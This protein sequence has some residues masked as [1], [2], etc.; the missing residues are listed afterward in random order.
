VSEDRAHY[1]DEDRANNP[2]EKHATMPPAIR[3][4]VPVAVVPPQPSRRER[5][6]PS[7]RERAEPLRPA[8]TG[9]GY[10]SAPSA[11]TR[12]AAGTVIRTTARGLGELLITL[13]AIVLLFAAYEFW[14]V[15]AIV[16]A[17]QDDL[18]RQLEQQWQRDTPTVGPTG[19]AGTSAP[20]PAPPAE[21]S[22]IGKLY[23]PRLNKWWVVVQGVTPKDIRYHPGHYPTTAMPGQEG[24]FSVAGH[25]NRATFW[26][27]D[28]MR[29]DDPIVVRTR[30]TW[31][32]YR[33]STTR[34][35]APTQ[36]EV[37]S[38]NPPGQHATRLLT[39]TTCNPK[40]DNY[41]RLIVHAEY[42]REQPTSAGDPVEL[43]G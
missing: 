23:L 16:D 5:A 39:L 33:V 35:V 19:S 34:V 8:G 11:P 1:P 29:N 43:K 4:R 18:A 2:D 12:T 15:S 25:R 22:G 42:V 40:L 36:V 14:G 27:L 17:H 38:P 41:Q 7:R 32:V 9:D 10:R 30:D 20:A 21:A 3:E 6:E 13:G 31:Y 28:R 24:N 26:D 37:V